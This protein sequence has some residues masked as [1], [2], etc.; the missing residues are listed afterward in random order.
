ML[1]APF[2]I[3][4]ALAR[5]FAAPVWLGFIFLLDP[6]NARLGAET[7]TR[8]R[9]INLSW[10]GLLCGV[11]WELWNFCIVHAASL[12]RDFDAQAFT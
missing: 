5:Y 1:A 11:L 8:E 6:I 12:V 9:M 7:L 4:P 10:S 3:S 2:F